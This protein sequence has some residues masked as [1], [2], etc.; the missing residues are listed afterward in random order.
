MKA[1]RTIVIHGIIYPS[2]SEWEQFHNG[3]A[4]I[5]LVSR[6]VSMDISILFTEM[7]VLVSYFLY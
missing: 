1:A 6:S 7:I 5:S 2:A 4:P 3:S